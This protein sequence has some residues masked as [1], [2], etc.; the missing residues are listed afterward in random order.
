MKR[1][2][3]WSL[4]IIISRN[5]FAWQRANAAKDFFFAKFGALSS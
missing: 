3:N 4:K 1:N 2:K 5:I